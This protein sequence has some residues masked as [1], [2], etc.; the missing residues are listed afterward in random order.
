MKKIN[1]K[2]IKSKWTTKNK[3]IDQKI[4]L[5]VH[6]LGI[7]ILSDLDMERD[8]FEKFVGPEHIAESNM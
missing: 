2:I 6:S 4:P 7:S 5:F 8:A 1:K 3:K